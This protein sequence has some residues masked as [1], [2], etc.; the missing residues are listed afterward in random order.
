LLARADVHA[1]KGDFDAALADATRAIAQEPE[2]SEAYYRRG[3]VYGKRTRN[4]YLEDA[5]AS[6]AFSKE[7]S[8]AAYADFDKALALDPKKGEALVAKTALRQYFMGSGFDVLRPD[9]TR[10]IEILSARA[11]TRALAD[12]YYHR[13]N[14]YSLQQKNALAIADFTSAIK[15]NPDHVGAYSLRATVNASPFFN[16]NRNVDAAI[17]DYSQ[18][19]RIKPSGYFYRLRGELFEENGE[20]A[21]AIADYRAAFSLDPNDY[22]TRQKLSKLAPDAL[23]APPK[24]AGPSAEQFAAEGRRKLA[25]KDYDGAINSLNECLRIKP[26]AAPCYAFRGYAQG[27]KANMAAANSD[28]EAAV[29]L[30]PNEPAIYFVRG[31]MLVELGNKAGAIAQFR[32]V[33]KLDPNNKQAQAALQNLGVAP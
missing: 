15:Y 22:P 4:T 9:Y 29:K 2:S 12:A 3:A 32:N 26:D 28:H 11:D 16:P 13:G 21:K 6:K 23:A 10:A 27:M 24:A 14:M 31:M 5:A 33:L 1:A 20:M 25:Q 8:E 17:A 7:S 19:L 30:S 18:V